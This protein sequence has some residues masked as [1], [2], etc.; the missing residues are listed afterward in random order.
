MRTRDP[1]QRRSRYDPYDIFARVVSIGKGG[2]L[3]LGRVVRVTSRP[4]LPSTGHRGHMPS[5]YLGMEV[6]GSHA[7]GVAWDQMQGRFPDDVY[8]VIPLAAF[9]GHR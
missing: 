5:E 8:R 4:Q 2:S 9:N 6:E 3:R 7:I 1:P